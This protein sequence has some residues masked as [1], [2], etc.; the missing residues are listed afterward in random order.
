MTN[1][2]DIH[3]KLEL[4]DEMVTYFSNDWY[5]KRSRNIGGLIGGLTIWMRTSLP[6]GI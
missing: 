6:Q 3:R 5:Y 4:S 1:E 2:K